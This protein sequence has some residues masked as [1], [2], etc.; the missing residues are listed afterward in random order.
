MSRTVTPF[1]KEQEESEQC[2]SGKGADDGAGDL[3]AI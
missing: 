3:A 2:E 1:E